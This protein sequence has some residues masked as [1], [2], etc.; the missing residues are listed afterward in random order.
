MNIFLLTF[1][2]NEI[3]NVEVSLTAN[4]DIVNRSGKNYL[5]IR[6]LQPKLKIGKFF[7]KSNCKN[8]SSFISRMIDEAIN[9]S[10]KIFLKAFEPD[11]NKYIGELVLS[12]VSPIFDKIPIEDFIQ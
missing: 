9:L 3:D 4:C 5:E 7:L 10:W 2:P 8:V 6:S 1:F 11:L 12:I